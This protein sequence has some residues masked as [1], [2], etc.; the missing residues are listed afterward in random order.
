[1]LKTLHD[2]LLYAQQKRIFL[3]HIRGK[4]EKR[5]SIMPPNAMLCH[6]YRDEKSRIYLHDNNRLENCIVVSRHLLYW[7]CRSRG[8]PAALKPLKRWHPV[9]K[10]VEPRWSS[11]AITAKRGTKEDGCGV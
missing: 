11:L 6:I 5:E 3:V 9:S 4:Q 10:K 2:S 8:S 1:M 7:W